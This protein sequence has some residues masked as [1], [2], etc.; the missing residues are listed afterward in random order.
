MNLNGDI[1]VVAWAKALD[2]L[3]LKLHEI[4]EQELAQL[5]G[6]KI[7]GGLDQHQ[8]MSRV[9]ARADEI[10]RQLA[11]RQV[12]YTLRE[13]VNILKDKFSAT[14]TPSEDTNSRSKVSKKRNYRNPVTPRQ[15]YFEDAH[16][17]RYD[18]MWGPSKNIST[19]PKGQ[20]IDPERRIHTMHY[21]KRIFANHPIMRDIRYEREQFLKM[22]GYTPKEIRQRLEESMSEAIQKLKEVGVWQLIEKES[23]TAEEIEIIHEA[24]YEFTIERDW[25][26]SEGI[27]IYPNEGSWWREIYGVNHVPS[28]FD[29]SEDIKT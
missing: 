9:D 19:E 13:A 3:P 8:L 6:F 16:P 2:L 17:G 12:P 23:L 18:G 29:T 26:S 21:K 10:R 14:L 24:L 27:T 5:V 4:N 25:E 20:V 1:E 7:S 15:M 28:P 22:I 11:Q